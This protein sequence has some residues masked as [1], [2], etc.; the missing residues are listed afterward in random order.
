MTPG[1]RE[2][3][4]QEEFSTGPLRVLT[5]IQQTLQ[6]GVG[7]G[8]GDVDWDTQDGE[9]QGELRTDSSPICS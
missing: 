8:H 7:A 4:E 2:V 6:H 1:E 9:R 5:G 3:K